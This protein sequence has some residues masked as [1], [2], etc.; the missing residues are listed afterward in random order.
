MRVTPRRQFGIGNN[1]I[2]LIALENIKRRHGAQRNHGAHAYAFKR[3][4]SFIGKP[5]IIVHEQNKDR[6]T[7]DRTPK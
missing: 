2:N 3:A 1:H 6:S 4:C 7:H 5:C